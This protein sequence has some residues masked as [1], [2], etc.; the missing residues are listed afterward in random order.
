LE[1]EDEVDAS[2]LGSSSVCDSL[3][4]ASGFGRL[5]T[6]EELLSHQAFDAVSG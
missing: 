3:E 1:E 2:G 5:E 4:S 6:S